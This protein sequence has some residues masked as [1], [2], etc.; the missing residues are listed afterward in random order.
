MRKQGA[1]KSWIRTDTTNKRGLLALSKDRYKFDLR[2]YAEEKNVDFNNVSTKRLR[3]LIYEYMQEKE[4]KEKEEE[5]HKKEA[6]LKRYI[7]NA[8]KEYAANEWRNDMELFFTGTKQ[9]ANKSLPSL[10]N[11]MCASKAGAS[12][13]LER[14]YSFARTPEKFCDH[15][16]WAYIFGPNSTT[17]TL[18]MLAIPGVMDNPDVND[19]FKKFLQNGELKE[20]IMEWYNNPSRSGAC[21]QLSSFRDNWDK[22]MQ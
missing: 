14:L 6:Q 10:F 12:V 13:T 16:Q 20:C 1:W 15:A 3:Q 8:E 2:T 17:Y 5:K 9:H 4:G 7:S 21:Q 22:L 11:T 19:L 18:R